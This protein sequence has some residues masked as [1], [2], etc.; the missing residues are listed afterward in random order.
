M[1][2]TQSAGQPPA[3]PEW[4]FGYTGK[5]MKIPTA[6]MILS[7]SYALSSYG[8]EV[9]NQASLPE[10][11]ESQAVEEGVD[12]QYSG[13][14]VRTRAPK[15]RRIP[16]VRQTRPV[17]SAKS[18]Y[19]PDVDLA[20]APAFYRKRVIQFRNVLRR[21]KSR[22]GQIRKAVQLAGNPSSRYQKDAIGFLAEV[23]SKEAVMSLIKLSKMR[24]HREVREF[25]IHALGEIRDPRAMNVLIWGLSDVNENVRG[26]AQRALQNLTRTD[27]IYQYD[28]STERREK[29][30]REIREW[31]RKMAPTF[32]VQEETQEEQ[33][34]AEDNWQK[35]GQ[36]YLHD[37][38]R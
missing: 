16:A 34:L 25:M 33:K 26:N 1:K 23:R 30:I 6:F 22:S 32:K 8:G 3:R 31:W 35:Y 7:M 5:T 28:D 13:S 18:T 2:G 19:N 21:Q 15:T 38:S 36:Q 37:L 29:G 10:I 20:E 4:R 27:F 24:K 9:V 11:S 12:N 14:A 17:V